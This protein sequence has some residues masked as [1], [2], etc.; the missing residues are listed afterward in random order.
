MRGEIADTLHFAEKLLVGAILMGVTE[1]M[2]R[3]AVRRLLTDPV[4]HADHRRGIETAAQFGAHRSA[5]RHARLD[6]LPKQLQ[7]AIFVLPVAHIAGL[8][9]KRQT[10]EGLLIDFI[11]AD[12]DDTPGRNRN[13]ALVRRRPGGTPAH[14]IAGN[15]GLIEFRQPR[16]RH[17]VG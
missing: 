9:M 1:G 16:P 4:R 14:Q 3:G 5:G 6:R 13:D 2:D 8:L 11:R 10:P 12:T 7:Q 15:V 17:Q